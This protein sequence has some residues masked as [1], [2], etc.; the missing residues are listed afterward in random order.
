MRLIRIV[1]VRIIWVVGIR[2]VG[3]REPEPDGK[4]EPDEDRIRTEETAIGEKAIITEKTAINKKTIIGEKVAVPNK[5]AT[6]E[7]IKSTAGGP[8]LMP[9]TSTRAHPYVTASP[10]PHVAAKR[11]RGDRQSPKDC[12]H[13]KDTKLF[14]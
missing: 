2:V 1:G 14:H 10:S 9:K 8:K 13:Q 12:G 7:S 6:A 4:S 3:I 5:R 11:P